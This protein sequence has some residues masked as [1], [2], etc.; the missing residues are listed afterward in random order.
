MNTNLHY[1]TKTL[2]IFDV[3]IIY[4]RLNVT[5]DRQT[6]TKNRYEH[7]KQNAFFLVT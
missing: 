6:N 4:R 3:H 7:R 2:P 1:F 5:K